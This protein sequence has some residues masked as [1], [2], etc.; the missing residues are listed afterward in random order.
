MNSKFYHGAKPVKMLQFLD[1]P[2]LFFN[3]GRSN[4]FLKV[5]DL[6]CPI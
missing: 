5:K 3:G 6:G 1:A 4:G 2:K